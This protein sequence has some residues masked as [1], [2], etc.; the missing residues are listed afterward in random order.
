MGYQGRKNRKKSREGEKKSKE[1]KKDENQ[2]IGT[3]GVQ[4]WDEACEGT[5]AQGF[6]QQ[7]AVQRQAGD[8]TFW[9][10]QV[11]QSS[12]PK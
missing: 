7:P 11:L 4:G 6:F 2:Q 10:A 9:K 8:V 3:D 5:V 1:N 12:L